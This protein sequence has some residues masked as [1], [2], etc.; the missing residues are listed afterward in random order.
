M[1]SNYC[2]GLWYVEICFPRKC[3]LFTELSRWLLFLKYGHVKQLLVGCNVFR[4]IPCSNYHIICVIQ[5]IYTYVPCTCIQML[6]T[7]QCSCNILL[8][9]SED[10]CSPCLGFLSD[11]C[12]CTCFSNDSCY[13]R[14]LCIDWKFTDLLRN[15]LHGRCVLVPFWPTQYTSCSCC[16]CVWYVHHAQCICT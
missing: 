3:K 13:V 16:T 11:Y 1:I 7:L 5:P 6:Q 15:C 2:Y 4:C 9:V 14:L 8:Y 10:D 12:V